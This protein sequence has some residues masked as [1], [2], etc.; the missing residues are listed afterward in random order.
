MASQPHHHEPATSTPL[1]SVDDEPQLAS[2]A[3]LPPIFTVGHSN[4]SFD[5]FADVLRSHHITAIADVRSRPYSRYLKH[6]GREALSAS[7]RAAG[8]SYVYLGSEL[9]GMP[10]DPMLY[11]P[12]GTLDIPKVVASP[13]FQSGI[14]RV[15][16]GMQRYRIALMCAEDDPLHC[17]RYRLLSVLLYQTGIEVMH[18]RHDGRIESM[19]DVARRTRPATKENSPGAGPQKDLFG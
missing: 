3:V 18:L 7:A 17:H 2:S 5:E 13:A 14:Q 1:E 11:R 4:R 6:F 12:D 19:D 16:R 8:L 15:R 9:G 10:N